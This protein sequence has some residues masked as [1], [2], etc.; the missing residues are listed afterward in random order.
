MCVHQRLFFVTSRAL[1]LVQ[2]VSFDPFRCLTFFTSL[3]S[4]SDSIYL[5]R[6]CTNIYLPERSNC[7]PNSLTTLAHNNNDNINSN[8]NNKPQH[9]TVV[10]SS[11]IKHDSANTPLSYWSTNLELLFWTYTWICGRSFNRTEWYF[12]ARCLLF[13]NEPA[14]V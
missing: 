3:F 5:F 12:L 7:S 9:F 6:N 11:P 2:S 14:V 4:T 8:N 13:H 10:V 1:N